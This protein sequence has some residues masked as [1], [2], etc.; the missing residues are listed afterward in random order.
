V[1]MKPN[2]TFDMLAHYTHA[3]RRKK[4]QVTTI[5]CLLQSTLY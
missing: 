1:D 4:S 5:E 3:C 2:N